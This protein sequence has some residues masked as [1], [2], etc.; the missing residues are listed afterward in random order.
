MVTSSTH[1]TNPTFP[2]SLSP[3]LK[4][5]HTTEEIRTLCQDLKVLGKGDF[6]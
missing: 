6:R 3:I 2:F 5:P 4:C 1:L